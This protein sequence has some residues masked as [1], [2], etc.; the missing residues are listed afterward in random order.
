[1][2]NHLSDRESPNDKD[3]RQG[4]FVNTIFVNFQHILHQDPELAD[5]IQGEFCRFEPYMRRA[6][7]SFVVDLH[8]TIKE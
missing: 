4:G 3:T 8:P 1:M 7:A 5:A 6:V 2:A